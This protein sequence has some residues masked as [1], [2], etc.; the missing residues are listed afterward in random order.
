MHQG[1]GCVAACP[2]GGGA[3]TVTL[4]TA[5][6]PAALARAAARRPRATTADPA[7]A[8]LR[9][10]G[11]TRRTSPGHAGDAHGTPTRCAP[12]G[13]SQPHDNMPPYLAVNFIISLFGI[14]PS[15]T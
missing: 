14:F 1:P 5:Q 10:P 9:R 3:E 6:M 12:A 15:E 7:D 8:E 4:T 13:G 2:G 11:R